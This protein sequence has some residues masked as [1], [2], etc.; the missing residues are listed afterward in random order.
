VGKPV[1]LVALGALSSLSDEERYRK[2]AE[3]CRQMA[4]KV[5]SPL[6]KEAWLKLAGD[7]LADDADLREKP[8]EPWSRLVWLKV[9]LLITG[10]FS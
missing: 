2:R 10:Q 7:W 5:I 3:D 6:Y 9:C 8:A 4:V 1:T